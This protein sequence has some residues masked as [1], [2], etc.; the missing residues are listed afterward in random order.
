MTRKP[1]EVCVFCGSS[2]PEVPHPNAH[3]VAERLNDTMRAQML[4][5][6]TL[7][8]HAHSEFEHGS[9]GPF[10]DRPPVVLP[11]DNVVFL[12]DRPLLAND[13]GELLTVD[14]FRRTRVC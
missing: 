4:L 12:R 10:N 13:D 1:I 3:K 9:S 8:M 14:T 11:G 5:R 2:E 7:R 6:E